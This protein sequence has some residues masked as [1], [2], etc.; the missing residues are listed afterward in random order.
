MELFH[1]Q[2][3]YVVFFGLEATELHNDLL[4]GFG[5]GRFVELQEGLFGREFEAVR[6]DPIC[7]VCQEA[8]AAAPS[9]RVLIHL[10]LFLLFFLVHS[11]SIDLSSYVLSNDEGHTV[12]EAKG[13]WVGHNLHVSG[14]TFTET[15]AQ[16]PLILDEGLKLKSLVVQATSDY[17]QLSKP[18]EFW[19]ES[20]LDQ[21]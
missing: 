8:S 21:H 18:F 20:N 15:V 10:I 17:L 19:F 14:D 7:E 5:G 4:E 9:L 11:H 16:V 3:L 12:I 13:L 1:A 2:L 6:Y